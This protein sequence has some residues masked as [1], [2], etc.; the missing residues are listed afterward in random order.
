MSALGRICGYET[1]RDCCRYEEGVGLF[2]GIVRLHVIGIY[3]VFFFFVSCHFYGSRDTLDG[4]MVLETLQAKTSLV[5]W[6]V[7]I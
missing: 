6:C 5:I 4:G 7:L 2:A 1:E 3:F